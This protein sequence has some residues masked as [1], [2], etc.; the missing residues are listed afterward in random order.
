[1]FITCVSIS[2]Y[3]EH[4]EE[5]GL[6]YA[7]GFDIA[8]SCDCCSER[9]QSGEERHGSAHDERLLNNSRRTGQVVY[10]G[11]LGRRRRR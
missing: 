7:R 8:Y 4:T 10:I 6:S 9:H 5:I 3:I 2:I 1:M 11:E